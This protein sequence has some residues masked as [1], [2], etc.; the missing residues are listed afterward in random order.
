MVPV[1]PP[2]TELAIAFF[3]S[4]LTING[5]GNWTH[6]NGTHNFSNSVPKARVPNGVFHEFVVGSVVK[7]DFNAS[8]GL[9]CESKK[10]FTDS[11][12]YFGL[13]ECRV[14]NE[15]PEVQNT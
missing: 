5:V 14:R 3:C 8:P 9:G 4:E 1:Q 12:S 15:S 6:I 2:L 13:G 10:P 11:D 7:S